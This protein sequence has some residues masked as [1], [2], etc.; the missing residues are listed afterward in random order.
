[1]GFGTS[2]PELFVGVQAALGGDTELALGNIVGSNV[3]N[4]SVVLGVGAIITPLYAAGRVV[5]REATYGVLSTLFYAAAMLFGAIT[6]F[7]GFPNRAPLALALISFGGFV[8]WRQLKEAKTQRVQTD[9]FTV[10]T[11]KEL[12][13]IHNGSTTKLV[14]KT[15]VGLVG[16]VVAAQILVTSATGIAETIGMSQIAI[17]VLLLALGT[18]LPELGAV[19]AGA[20]HG[21]HDLILGNLWGSTLFNATIVGGAT[22]LAGNAPQISWWVVV[23]PAAVAT[24]AWTLTLS[25]EKIV[26]WEGVLLILMGI[27]A[28]L[29]LVLGQ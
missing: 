24:L 22:L 10:E 9:E 25:K 11:K 1:M 28:T 13:S 29:F 17:G 27:V 23:L 7:A 15:V 4:L 21:E 18:S 16:L 6:V 3:A 19:I 5:R 2:L 20:R 14:I 8:I 12:E 26:R